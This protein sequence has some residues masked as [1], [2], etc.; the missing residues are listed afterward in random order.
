MNRITTLLSYY[1][2]TL[3]SHVLSYLRYLLNKAWK[4][5]EL[6]AS[7][8]HLCAWQ[9]CGADPSKRPTLRQHGK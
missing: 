1:L 9:D 5:W 7:Q 2:F 4:T 3:L 6:Q 8:S